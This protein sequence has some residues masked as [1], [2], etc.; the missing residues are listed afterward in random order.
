MEA[1]YLYF[2]FYRKL[3]ST[4]CKKFLGYTKLRET[5]TI[6]TMKEIL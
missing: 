5:L 1:L 3:H 6:L 4:W 2:N